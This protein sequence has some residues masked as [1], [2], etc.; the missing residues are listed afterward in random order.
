MH[1]EKTMAK[2]TIEDLKHTRDKA[3]GTVNLRDG[4]DRA[5]ITVHMGIYVLLLAPGL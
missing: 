5:K 4:V 3:R 1:E 2:L